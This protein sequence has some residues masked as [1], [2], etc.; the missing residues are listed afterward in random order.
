MPPKINRI[1]Q[2]F[3]MLLIVNQIYKNGEAYVICICDCGSRKTIKLNSLVIG[4]TKS[5]GCQKKINRIGQIFGKLTIVGQYRKNGLTY[6]NCKCECGNKKDILM[7]NIVS[8]YTISCGCSKY[9]VHGYT[10]TRTYRIYL[11]MKQRCYN[12]NKNGYKDYGA[13]G[14]IV[15][16]RWLGENGFENFLEDMG[17]CPGKNHSIE[18]IDVNGNYCPENTRW[19]TN[20]EQQNNKR[21]NHFIVFMKKTKTIAEWGREFKIKYGSIYHYLKKNNW[22]IEAALFEMG[23]LDL[24]FNDSSSWE[25]FSIKEQ[26]VCV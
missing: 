20:I 10:G 5:C 13:R 12:K 15:C 19:A 3:G 11:H 16:D 14:I 25:Y 8:G 1:G 6:A 18:R 21:D 4:R 24:L 17:E 23:R 2:K 22:N 9:I 26:K 7:S